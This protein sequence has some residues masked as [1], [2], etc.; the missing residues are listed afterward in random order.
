MD[1]W[2]R[3]GIKS[4]YNN[5]KF[6]VYTRHFRDERELRFNCSRLVMLSLLSSWPG[7]LHFCSPQDN[8]GFKAIVEVLYLN[9]LEVRV[10][11]CLCNKKFS[12]KKLYRFLHV[13]TFLESRIGFNV[14]ASGITTTRMDR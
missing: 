13:L 4:K 14:R 10:C 8:S 3:I 1:G 6:C 7:I 12:Y 2:I 11:G 9:Q 5:N